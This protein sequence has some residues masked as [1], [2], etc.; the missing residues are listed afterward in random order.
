MLGTF[1]DYSDQICVFSYSLTVAVLILSVLVLK[2]LA[3]LA[4]ETF[5]YYQY[6]YGCFAGK[7]EFDNELPSIYPI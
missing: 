3:N 1:V 4:D 7:N 5:P 6:F 2:W